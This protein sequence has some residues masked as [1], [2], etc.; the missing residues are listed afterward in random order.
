MEISVFHLNE[1]HA[2]FLTL[3]LMDRVMNGWSLAEAIE[4]VRSS[5]VFTTHTPVPAGIDRFHADLITPY[6]ALWAE[7]WGTDLAQVWELGADP[8]HA[9]SFNMAALALR[10]CRQANGVS[11]LHGEVSRNLFSGVGMGDSI[12]HV[13]NGVHARTWVSEEGQSVFDEVAGTSWDSGDV[14]AW[15]RIAQLDGERIKAIKDA[16]VAHLA[17]LVGAATGHKLRPDSLVIGFARRFAPYKRAALLFE[18]EDALTD[19]LDDQDRPV[20]FLYAGKAHPMDE[21]GK[22]LI[23]KIVDFA[24]RRGAGGGFTFIPGYDMDIARALVAGCDIWLNTPIR[25]REASGTSGQKAALNG[26]LNCSILDG[27]WAEMFESDNGWAIPETDD[28]ETRDQAEARATLALLEEIALLYH[29]RPEEFIARIRSS[30]R[31]LGPRVTAARMLRDYEETV[32][33]T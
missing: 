21:P 20:H 31:T 1:G 18:Q 7:R 26:G 33:L 15:Q 10:L 3:D 2:G 24:E 4:S 25:P 17:D 9:D 29:Q 14:D 19:L 30:W 23:S 6:L 28:A 5:L 11:Q 27:W 22:E 8:E 32:Y 13:T 12:T 16:N